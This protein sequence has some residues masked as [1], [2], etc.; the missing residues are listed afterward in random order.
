MR[1]LRFIYLFLTRK[2]KVSNI[3]YQYYWF[4]AAIA[5][6]AY[7]ISMNY[8][9]LLKTE[10]APRGGADLHAAKTVER[11]DQIMQTWNFQNRIDTTLTECRPTTC[12]DYRPYHIK[13]MIADSIFSIAFY[14]LLLYFLV[15]ARRWFGDPAHARKKIDWGNR[16]IVFLAILVSFSL[17]SDL[18][19]NFL[20]ILL[21]QDHLAGSPLSQSL[22]SWVFS[23]SIVKAVGWVAAIGYIIVSILFRSSDNLFEIY[24]VLRNYCMLS[25]V[26]ILLLFF[27]FWGQAQGQ[28]LLIALNEKP[29]Q[30]L[31]TLSF[32]FILAMIS[33]ISPRFFIVKSLLRDEWKE[34]LEQKQGGGWFS[35]M[36]KF[37]VTDFSQNLHRCYY[38]SEDHAYRYRLH[39]N[40][41]RILG[42]LSILVVYGAFRNVLDITNTPLFSANGW[43]L[44]TFFTPMQQ[45]LILTG[46][47]IWLLYWDFP[48]RPKV[49]KTIVI[50]LFVLIGLFFFLDFYVLREDGLPTLR[51]IHLLSLSTLAVAVL[52]F[53]FVTYRRSIVDYDELKGDVISIRDKLMENP[54]MKEKLANTMVMDMTNEAEE[55]KS[56]YQDNY[57]QQEGEEPEMQ[58]SEDKSEDLEHLEAALDLI[59][60]KLKESDSSSSDLRA[61]KNSIAFMK[62]KLGILKLKVS[63][64]VAV[65]LV[66]ALIFFFVVNIASPLW[67]NRFGTLGVVLVA[68]TTYISILT[69]IIFVYGHGRN[70]SVIALILPVLFLVIPFFIR[71]DN[72]FYDVQTVENTAETNRYSLD[73][74]FETWVDQRKEDISNDESYPVFI[75]ASNGGG[76]RAAYWTTSLLAKL[77]DTTDGKFI[78]HL[79]AT[80][81]ASGGS[82]GSAV[83][84][85]LSAHTI[86]NEG[87]YSKMMPRVDNIFK[88][89]YL[90]A[91]VASLF[92]RDFI[93][94]IIP[95]DIRYWS[96]RSRNLGYQYE[97]MIAGQTSS[98]NNFFAEEFQKVWYVGKDSVNTHIPLYFGNTLQVEDGRRGVSSAVDMVDSIF[99]DAIDVLKMRD[100]SQTLKLSSASMLT[101]RFPFVNP[102]GRIDLMTGPG[103]FAD[104]GYFDNAGA[105]TAAEV[106]GELIKM[107]RM[108]TQAGSPDSLLYSHLKFYV[109]KIDNDEGSDAKGQIKRS[110]PEGKM[111]QLAAPAQAVAQALLAGHVSYS[112]DLLKQL[113]QS[114]TG[115]CGYFHFWLPYGNIYQRTNC[116]YQPKGDC[117]VC[118]DRNQ[119]KIIPLGRYLS[120]SARAKIEEGLDQYS[121]AINEVVGK[122]D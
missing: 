3:I 114:D 46:I 100:E 42:V 93:Q 91:T 35:Y 24:Y 11:A 111:S 121:R 25:V 60:V 77:S 96:N 70:A 19:E 94:N 57:Y 33:W 107:K 105:L 118:D 52:F 39:T 79:F 74:Y 7:S 67:A 51:G 75:V 34:Q 90:S 40:I 17:L 22:V 80:S 66:A 63:Y 71:P 18:C 41:P 28:D 50:C 48:Y 113:V 122:F 104:G 43:S 85:A 36:W 62:R 9:E 112:D 4:V 61:V 110:R 103:H 89:D 64:L 115:E 108:H 20:S 49:V 102:V 99:V 12:I 15:Q 120:S 30:V 109:L 55:A 78:E 65:G 116:G 6:V 13:S 59:E 1:I 92:G 97:Q 54:E 16:L 76:S 119:Q 53:L 10:T 72:N 2:R 73:K 27:L 69:L 106:L 101:N 45:V 14:F 68:L 56:V 87:T 31:F 83:F 95:W 37:Y 44:E 58:V 29:G 23:F 32:V 98:T 47:C 117:S 5:A 38:Y 82:V 86:R 26:S 81:G 21:V 88:E 84:T 8:N